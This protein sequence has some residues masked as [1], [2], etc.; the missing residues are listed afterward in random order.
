MNAPLITKTIEAA[1][2]SAEPKL[3]LVPKDAPFDDAQRQWLNGLLTG[4]SA[5][6]ASAA[7]NAGAEEAPLACVNVLYGSQSGNCE[8]LTKDLRKFAPTQGFEA[9]IQTL[10]EITPADLSALSG[11]SPSPKVDTTMVTWVIALK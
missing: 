5:I 1:V 9:N 4:L 2:A 3:E 8:T 10:D 11:G 6:A 7:A